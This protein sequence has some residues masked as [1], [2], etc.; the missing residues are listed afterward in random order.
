[1]YGNLVTGKKFQSKITHF[2]L[3]YIYKSAKFLFFYNEYKKKFFTI[4]IE[5]GRDAP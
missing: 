4:E 3:N 1:M 2:C 5:D